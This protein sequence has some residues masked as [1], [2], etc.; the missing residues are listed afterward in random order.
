MQAL[1]TSNKVFSMESVTNVNKINLVDKKPAEPAT[2]KQIEEIKK[3]LRKEI[4]EYYENHDFNWIIENVGRDSEDVENYISELGKNCLKIKFSD[5]LDKLYEYY[6][7]AKNDKSE[8][9]HWD[10]KVMASYV[11]KYLTEKNIKHAYLHYFTIRNGE[12]IMHDVIIYSSKEKDGNI[13]R[14]CD[15]DAAKSNILLQKIFTGEIS[16]DLKVKMENMSIWKNIVNNEK[17]LKR[18]K[19]QWE[20]MTDTWLSMPLTVYTSQ[21]F[22][23]NNRAEAFV[24]DTNSNVYV[25]PGNYPNIFE[26][27][28]SV[29]LEKNDKDYF[30]KKFLN[31]TF[32]KEEILNFFKNHN[33]PLM[34]A[35]GKVLNNLARLRYSNLGD[36]N[37]DGNNTYVIL[38]NKGNITKLC[39]KYDINRPE[40]QIGFGIEDPNFYCISGFS[41]CE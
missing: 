28:L 21:E 25:I 40:N 24:I 16:K 9:I 38:L 19:E 35:Q 17:Y 14:V 41:V 34:I 30:S 1:G 26:N 10:C 7:L 39:K 2:A 32:S 4:S 3:C 11:D 36:I 6:K 29:W 27:Q 15:M 5:Y 37:N 31:E 8:K 33:D 13:W 23:M 20:K 22:G 18:S 12:N